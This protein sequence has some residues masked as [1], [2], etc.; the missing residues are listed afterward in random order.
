MSSNIMPTGVVYVNCLWLCAL[1]NCVHSVVTV[2]PD[3]R[4]QTMLKFVEVELQGSE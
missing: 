1:A 4:V 2:D 3:L